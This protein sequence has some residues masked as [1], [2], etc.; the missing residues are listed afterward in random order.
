M[1]SSSEPDRGATLGEIVCVHFLVAPGVGIG[2]ENGAGSPKSGNSAKALAP[3]RQSA[4]SAAAKASPISVV[5]VGEGVIS[6]G[7]PPRRQFAAASVSN[8]VRR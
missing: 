2:H 7:V 6:A 3:A 4:R 1:S 8:P 5:Q